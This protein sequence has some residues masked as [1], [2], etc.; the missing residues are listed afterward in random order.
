MGGKGRGARVGA[1]MNQAAVNYGDERRGLESWS[2]TAGG[3]GD[4]AGQEPGGPGGPSGRHTAAR[5]AAAPGDR[6]RDNSEPSRHPGQAAGA[7]SPP[8]LLV[9]GVLRAEVGGRGLPAQAEVRQAVQQAHPP[10]RRVAHARHARPPRPPP[11]RFTAARRRPPCREEGSR[12]RCAPAASWPGPARPRPALL[13]SRRRRLTA[14]LF[15]A[16]QPGPAPPAHWRRSSPGPAP[17]PARRL[18]PPPPPI[19]AARSV[20]PPPAPPV[21]APPLIG[22]ARRLAPPPAV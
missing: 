2:T 9:L 19:G 13:R 14:S 11:R 4:R 7:R 5:G 20:A 15:T 17:A 1:G 8:H 12:V 18:A 3:G 22:A 21:P 10:G 16:P 6:R